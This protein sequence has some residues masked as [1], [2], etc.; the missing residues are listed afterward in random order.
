MKIQTEI[1]PGSSY[2]NL[3]TCVKKSFTW[4]MH[5]FRKFYQRRS[6]FKLDVLYYFD[7]FFLFF[8]YLVDEGREDPNT[9]INGPLLDSQQNAI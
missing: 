5:G 1:Y 9:T 2:A 6:N 7:T 8:N 3:N 4:N